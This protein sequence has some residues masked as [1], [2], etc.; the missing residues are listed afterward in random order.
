MPPQSPNLHMVVLYARHEQ[1]T[2]EPDELLTPQSLA[3]Q[4]C[5]ATDTR[6]KETITNA[7]RKTFLGPPPSGTKT[8][9]KGL[10]T[11]K[12]LSPPSI[13]CSPLL[14]LLIRSSR[15]SG[16]DTRIDLA[17]ECCVQPPTLQVQL[18]TRILVF[19]YTLLPRNSPF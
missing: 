2:G 10:R 8:P 18:L 11:A 16:N 1:H 15:V 5:T 14:R 19:G 3:V 17:L 12:H 6:D 9:R 7:S 13:T 4:R